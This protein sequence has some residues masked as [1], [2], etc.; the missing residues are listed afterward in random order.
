MFEINIFLWYT[1]KR[2]IPLKGSANEKTFLHHSCPSDASPFRR[3]LR[4]PQKQSLFLRRHR[5]RRDRQSRNRSYKNAGYSRKLSGKAQLFSLTNEHIC[6]SPFFPPPDII[7]MRK[8]INLY[9]T[10][11][12]RCGIIIKILHWR[13][14]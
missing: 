5:R 1:I 6:Y 14:T 2:T 7:N 11:Q 4:R 10:L 12:K 13:N 3:M 8:I 9:F